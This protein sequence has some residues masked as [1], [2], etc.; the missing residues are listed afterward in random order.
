M[1]ERNS[2]EQPTGNSL[3]ELLRAAAQPG[4]PEELQGM[5]AFVQQFTAEVASTTVTSRSTSMFASRITRRATAIV[6]VTLLA[7]GTAA[8]AA[9]GTDLN[10]FHTVELETELETD[11]ADGSLDDPTTTSDDESD[12]DDDSIILSNDDSDDDDHDDDDD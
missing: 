1:T 6:A 7:A 9:G 12:V 11:D 5:A 2:P 10:P 8:A 4:S 3:S